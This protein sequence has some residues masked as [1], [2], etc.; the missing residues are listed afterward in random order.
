MLGSYVK[1]VTRAIT[2]DH[3]PEAFEIRKNPRTPHQNLDRYADSGEAVIPTVEEAEDRQLPPRP[4]NEDE[5]GKMVLST[6]PKATPTK[7]KT[8]SITH[9]DAAST[10]K[11]G[12]ENL[13]IEGDGHFEKR[14]SSDATKSDMTVNSFRHI[15]NDAELEH[16]GVKEPTSH[17]GGSKPQ[18]NNRII[19]STAPSS[20][21]GEISPIEQ[22]EE[23]LEG[24]A[25]KDG[26]NKETRR[27]PPVQDGE[28]GIKT[29]GDQASKHEAHSMNQENNSVSIPIIVP[30]PLDKALSNHQFQTNTSPEPPETIVSVSIGRIEIRSFTHKDSS[31]RHPATAAAAPAFAPRMTITDYLKQREGA[32]Q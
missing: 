1:N 22:P 13:K 21:S 5:S 32:R 31:S 27:R 20:K 9:D 24:E 7:S 26:E 4:G 18:T 12:S 10:K 8:Q 19:K 3:I 29:A 28:S 16:S 11:T 6:T 30:S 23:N 25:V 15:G 2:I 17:E 14:A